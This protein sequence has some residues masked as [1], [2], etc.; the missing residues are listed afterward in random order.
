M[1]K[2][3]LQILAHMRISASALS[4]LLF[5][6]IYKFNLLLVCVNLNEKDSVLFT[7]EI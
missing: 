3:C 7:I 1:N 2:E 6:L 5:L 4:A